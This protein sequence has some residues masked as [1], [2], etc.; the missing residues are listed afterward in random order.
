MNDDSE[1]KAEAN[2]NRAPMTETRRY[3]V[4]ENLGKHERQFGDVGPRQEP[5]TENPNNMGMQNSKQRHPL[6][7]ESQQFSGV[8]R[9]GTSVISHNNDPNVTDDLVANAAEL[10]K[11]Y[12]ELQNHPALT[13]GM[14]MQME[15][16]KRN[17]YQPKT[18]P[19]L[20][21]NPYQ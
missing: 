17:E 19:V 20:K 9:N 18:A 10:A 6:L 11:K 7:D 21:V 4:Q 3:A 13:P 5:R 12:P 16:Q 14:R 2:N 1:I 8:P 15:N